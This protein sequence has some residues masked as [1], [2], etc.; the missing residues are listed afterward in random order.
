LT[1]IYK[2][3]VIFLRRIYIIAFLFILSRGILIVQYTKKKTIF[4]TFMQIY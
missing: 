4:G 1:V 2:I 3:V